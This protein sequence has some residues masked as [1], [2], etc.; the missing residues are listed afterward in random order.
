[1]SKHDFGQSE[2]R[3]IHFA[4]GLSTA[5]CQR[6]VFSNRHYS[7]SSRL[8]PDKS[9]PVFQIH[10]FLKKSDV[11]NFEKNSE[12]KSEKK[13]PEPIRRKDYLRQWD[14]EA[15]QCSLIHLLLLGLVNSL[16]LDM[17]E[18]QKEPHF[19]CCLH[20]WNQYQD[21]RDKI[22]RQ[23]RLLIGQCTYEMFQN[24]FL[25]SSRDLSVTGINAQ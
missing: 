22:H 8:V 9:F 17:T 12:I 15:S 1:M 5:I 21:S 20:K 23:G 14:H 24:Q 18:C 10:H 3:Y 2:L 16:K 6:L 11:K 7:N 25:H 19:H 13:N 4:F